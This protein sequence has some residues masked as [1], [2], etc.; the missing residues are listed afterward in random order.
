MTTTVDHPGVVTAVA[1]V[2]TD[3]LDPDEVLFR[4]ALA[5]L[6]E[7]Q[8]RFWWDIGLRDPSDVR[9]A[10][11]AHVGTED[12]LHYTEVG[13]TGRDIALHH[14]AGVP[15]EVAAVLH[16]AGHAEPVEQR[17]YVR[18]RISG[19]RIVSFLDA[20]WFDLADIETLVDNDVNVTLARRC[21]EH[22]LSDATSVVA[23]AHRGVGSNEFYDFATAG[24]TDLQRIEEHLDVDIR[25]RDARGFH[26]AGID[27]LAERVAI[28]ER[29]VPGSD[30][31]AFTDMGVDLDTAVWLRTR[32]VTGHFTQT[33]RSA[34]PN[35]T[36]ADL[37]R[38]GDPQPGRFA[39]YGR[40]GFGIDEALALYAAD[41]TPTRARAFLV[42]GVTDA[43]AII[44]LVEAKV[45]AAWVQ[46][47]LIA[48]VTDIDEMVARH[49]RRQRP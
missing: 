21:R 46:D 1:M 16:T 3:G 47:F 7:D 13:I 42:A 18:R 20:G 31:A 30:L 36:P 19:A 17:R 48:G 2:D 23:L 33:I 28:T 24:L 29:G 41:I 8:I 44:R 14:R 37:V 25:G 5:D 34:W 22:G 45:P 35:V 39:D 38:I 9:A 40:R 49:R 12:A 6:T 4:L 26:R 32:G 43:S 10:I 27:D 11:D 15:P